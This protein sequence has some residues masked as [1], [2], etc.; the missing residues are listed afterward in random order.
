MK[1][2]LKLA[3]AIFSESPV[4]LLDEPLQIWTVMALMLYQQLIKEYAGKRMVVVS[5]NDNEEY[6][7]C[8]EL[9]ICILQ[10]IFTSAGWQST[11]SDLYILNRI[12][13]SDENW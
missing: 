4:L 1:Q 3:Q 7:F 5:S 10:I 6:Q 13:H 8:E 2:R 12:S 9:L 11:N